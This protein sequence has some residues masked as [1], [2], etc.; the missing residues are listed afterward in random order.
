MDAI[1]A[2][3]IEDNKTQSLV[4]PHTPK[5]EDLAHNEEGGLYHVGEGV[6]QYSDSGKEENQTDLERFGFTGL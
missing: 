2:Q 3:E 4:V 1:E 6:P 5:E